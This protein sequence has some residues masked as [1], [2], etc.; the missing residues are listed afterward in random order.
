V[1][2]V[3]AVLMAIAVPM[4][5]MTIEKGKATEIVKLTRNI[6][7]AAERYAFRNN[8]ATPDV[9]KYLDIELRGT[10]P[11]NN[12][13]Q[14]I[15]DFGN[16]TLSE[17]EIKGARNNPPASIG[18]YYFLIPRSGADEGVMFCC[19]QS[20]ANALKICAGLSSTTTEATGC[21]GGYTGYRM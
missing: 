4:Y 11:D 14:F 16:F 18:G 9:F 21:T 15:N 3:I 13:R 5:M 20:D 2:L 17:T 8:G 1:V 19:A 12:Q 7:D 10:I 6:Y